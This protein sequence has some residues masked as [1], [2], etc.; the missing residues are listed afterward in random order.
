[1]TDN[2]K[3]HPLLWITNHRSKDCKPIVVTHDGAIQE[4]TTKDALNEFITNFTAQIKLAEE[5]L[6]EMDS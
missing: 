6:K 5:L 1:M 2:L 4:G 3:H